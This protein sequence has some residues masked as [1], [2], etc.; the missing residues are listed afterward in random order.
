MIV[1]SL[2]AGVQSSTMALMAAHGEIDMPDCAIFADTGWEPRSVYEWLNWLEKQLPFPVHRVSAGNLRE[3]II[4]HSN[5]TGQRIAA[6]P[7]HMQDGM[8]RRQCTSE[9]KLTP[10]RRK[11]REL[12]GTRDRSAKCRVM[13]GISLDEAHR[14]KSSHNQWQI[15][16][17]PLLD[18]RMSRGDCLL[19]ME[20]NGYPLPPKSSCIGCPYHSDYQWQEI[21]NVPDEWNDVV[22]IDKLIR[23]QPKF[24]KQQFMHRSLKPIDEVKFTNEAQVDLFG[25]E[26]EGMCGV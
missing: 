15:H 19:W 13:I 4:N 2:G 1:L 10:L 17:W 12:L 9:Y 16:E 8:G 6:V 23:N 18:K 26:C 24:R 21:K 20:K 25:N 22:M 14:A 5:S 7:W 3:D 11:M